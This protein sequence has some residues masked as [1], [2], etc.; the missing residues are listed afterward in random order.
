MEKPEA[1]RSAE[2]W[3][4]LFYAA[5]YAAFDSVALQIPGNNVSTSFRKKG[6][7]CSLLK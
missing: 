1:L 2:L 7:I 4:L 5:F 6:I 3:L